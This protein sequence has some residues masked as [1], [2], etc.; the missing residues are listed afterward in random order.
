M[1]VDIHCHYTFARRLASGDERFSFE[2]LAESGAPALDSCVS[3][4]CLRRPAWR[5]ARRWLGLSGTASGGA[6]DAALERFYER[7]LTADGPVQRIVLLAFDRYHDD[8]GRPTRWPTSSRQRGS[9]I[10]TSNSLI[11][12]T[13]R[14]H[15]G[16]FLFGASVH[17]YRA[18]AVACVEEVFAGG[19]CLLKWIPLHQNIAPHDPRTRAVMRRCAELG[20]PL[21]VHCGAEF[22]LATQH[23][24][25]RPAAPWLAALAQLRREGT[26]PITIIAHVATPPTP[27]GGR[28][29]HQLLLDALL[30]D[31]ADAPLF[32]DVS[33]LT[34]W[35]KVGFLRA[36]ARRQDLHGKLLFGSDFPVPLGWPRLRGD[37]KAER[38]RIRALSSW[39]QQAAE[40]FRQTGYN[41]IVL[42]RAATLLPN[43]DSFAPPEPA[44]SA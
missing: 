43:V 21:L 31:F 26:M 44:R 12:Q 14:R 32:A 7:H 39:I 29:S 15:P 18:D 3:P 41:E 8:G 10:Y 9:D 11:A 27:L 13:C 25:Y 20:L 35:G 5:I 42:H 16:R 4:R 24:A 19:A 34:S 6:L 1:I 22:T 23:P 38:D 30:G 17:P 40:V 2:P 33:A 37:L 28:G 36:L